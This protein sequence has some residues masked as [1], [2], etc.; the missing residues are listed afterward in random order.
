[1]QVGSPASTME[2]EGLPYPGSSLSFL[3]EVLVAKNSMCDNNCENVK[4]Y[5]GAQ[6]TF[7]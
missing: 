1:M 6:S 3:V 2:L 4:M 7:I 5:L